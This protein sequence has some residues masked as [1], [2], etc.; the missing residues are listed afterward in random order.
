MV[1]SG[2]GIYGPLCYFIM[3]IM[4]EH[5]ITLVMCLDVCL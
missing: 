4:S 2:G 5:E 3:I 1:T